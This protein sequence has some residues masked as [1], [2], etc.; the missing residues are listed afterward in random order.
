MYYQAGSCFEAN[1]EKNRCNMILGCAVFCENVRLKMHNK[2]FVSFKF[3]FKNN[4]LGLNNI[5]YLH[6]TLKIRKVA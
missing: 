6:F 4:S 1:D 2:V 5:F 3:Y